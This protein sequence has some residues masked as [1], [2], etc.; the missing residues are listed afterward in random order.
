MAG[1]LLAPNLSLLLTPFLALLVAG[2]SA[3]TVVLAGVA[4]GGVLAGVALGGSLAAGSGAAAGGSDGAA[5]VTEGRAGQQALGGDHVRPGP[6]AL[7]ALAGV[8]GQ[9]LA[10][11]RGRPA[12]PAVHH[13]GELGAAG[14]RGERPH[15]RPGRVELGLHPLDAHRG[16]LPG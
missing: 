11:Q 5:T 2:G 15:H 1:P 8:P 4:L 6:V 16:V 12:V 3:A 9:P 7:R 14:P 13:G 10:P